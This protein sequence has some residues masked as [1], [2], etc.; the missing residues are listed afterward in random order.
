MRAKSPSGD[1]GVLSSSLLTPQPRSVGRRKFGHY[2][3]QFKNFTNWSPDADALNK[4]LK[5]FTISVGTD[6]FLY[7]PVKQNI[8]MF[9]EKKVVVKPLIVPGG[10]TWMNCKLYLANTLPQLFR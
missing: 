3:R 1:L 10:H 4:Q 8:A 5:L 2:K 6:D 7:E 9:N